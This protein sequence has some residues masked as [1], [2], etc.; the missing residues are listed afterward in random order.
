MKTVNYSEYKKE[1]LKDP[2]LKAEYDKL[3]EEFTLASE[4]IQL[5]KE[6]KLTQKE[7]AEIIGTSQPAIA[8]LESGSYNKVSLS[9]LRRVA[10]ALDAKLEIHLR[11]KVN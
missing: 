8:R 3:E 4:I 7:L 10:E 9:F 6:K 1:M 2:E 5:R 11:K